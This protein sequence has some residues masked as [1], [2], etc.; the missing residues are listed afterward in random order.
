MLIYLAGLRPE[1]RAA[2]GRIGVLQRLG[3][4][5]IFPEQEKDY[6]ATLNAIRAALNKVEDRAQ[7]DKHSPNYYLV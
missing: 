7:D 2:L 6:S 1:I 5:F 4:E 3:E